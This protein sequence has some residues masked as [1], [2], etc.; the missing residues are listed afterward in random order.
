VFSLTGHSLLIGDCEYGYNRFLVN[1]L[2]SQ[3]VIFLGLSFSNGVNIS[4]ITKL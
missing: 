2:T 4:F 1:L 3:V